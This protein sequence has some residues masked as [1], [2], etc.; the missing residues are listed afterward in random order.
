[1]WIGVGVLLGLVVVASVF[2]FHFGPHGHVLAAGLGALAAIWL[3]IMGA[4]GESRP[5]LWV[6][7]GADVA[8]SGGLG[9]LAWNGLKFSHSEH[10]VVGAPLVGAEGVALTDLVPQGIVRIRGES[11]SASSVNGTAEAGSAVQVI[12]GS[13]VRLNV[14]CEGAHDVEATPLADVSQ[15]GV[16]LADPLHEHRKTE[17]Q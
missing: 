17:A 5:L 7:L 14:W 9:A 10:H 11:W 4:T 6:L 12:D 13:G 2:G 16:Q 8:I 15:P 3:L 1:M